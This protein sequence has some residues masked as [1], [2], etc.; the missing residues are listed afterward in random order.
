M[1]MIVLVA[2]AVLG[3]PTK[4]DPTDV[5]MAGKKR[6]ISKIFY[7]NLEEDQ[8][9]RAQTETILQETGIPF[10]RIKSAT[11][12]ELKGG[13]YFDLFPE[14][15]ANEDIFRKEDSDRARRASSDL[16]HRLAYEM[17]SQFIRQIS[18]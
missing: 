12:K 16:S 6:E 17:V 11:P 2:L 4:R 10:V 18:G 3:L 5:A 8:T 9:H 1:G 13:M 14:T 15:P 7:L